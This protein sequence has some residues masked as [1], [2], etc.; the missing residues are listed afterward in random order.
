MIYKRFSQFLCKHPTP[1][2]VHFIQHFFHY[3]Y[4]RWII[5]PKLYFF[6]FLIIKSRHVLYKKTIQYW[7]KHVFSDIHMIN[8]Y[9]IR[10][11]PHRH[12]YK[13]HA[14]I[15]VTLSTKLDYKNIGKFLECSTL[16]ENHF[17]CLSNTSHQ[18]Q[19]HISLKNDFI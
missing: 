10:N 11:R 2:D 17:I 14:T 8:L 5:Q 19:Y 6:N 15:T 3:M 4:T 18:Y 7:K 9:Q 12:T 1:I 16:D 13:L